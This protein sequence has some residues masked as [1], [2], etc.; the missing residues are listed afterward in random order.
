MP[1]TPTSHRLQ[2]DLLRR[3][4]KDST[5]LNW[6]TLY[7]LLNNIGER[8]PRRQTRTRPTWS[9]ALRRTQPTIKR[10]LS[11]QHTQLSPAQHLGKYNP[12]YLP[13][14]SPRLRH[15]GRPSLPMRS[16]RTS[17]QHQA[18]PQ[19]AWHIAILN[20]PYH[21]PHQ[22]N[23]YQSKNRTNRSRSSTE[24]YKPSPIWH[25]LWPPAHIQR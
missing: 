16:S 4:D 17:S 19:M 25:P 20:R 21:A 3:L 18:S 23:Q 7:L 24:K 11:L 15:Q 6:L 5:Y 13:L 9:P 2:S 8:H 1:S 12:A 22:L 10:P 14:M